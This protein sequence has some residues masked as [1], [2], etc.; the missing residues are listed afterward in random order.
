MNL[1][2]SKHGDADFVGHVP[3]FL[4]EEEVNSLYSINKNMEWK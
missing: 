4:S 3:D 2:V 1:I